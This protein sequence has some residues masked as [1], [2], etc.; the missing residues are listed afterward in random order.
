M[1]HSF[2]IITGVSGSGKTLALK[3][4]EDV[5]YFCID[6]MPTPLILNLLENKDTILPYHKKIAF[7]VDIRNGEDFYVLINAIAP[8]QK[9]KTARMVYLDCSDSVLVNRYKETRRKHPLMHRKDYS[10][11]KAVAYEKEILRPLF[12][13]ADFIIDSSLLSSFQLKDKLLTY[14]VNDEKKILTINI[15]S[16]GFKF[17]VPSDIDMLF[18]VRCL[19]NPFYIKELRDLTGNDEKVSSYVL[20][21]DEAQALYKNQKDLLNTVLPLYIKEGET[22]LTIAF[23]C[24]GGKHRSITFT[25][26][27]YNDLLEEGYQV[28][29]SHRDEFR[30]K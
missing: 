28:V 7:V 17:G 9:D 22:N 6:N 18:D 16:F 4:L 14:A 30:R 25:N 8:L 11:E 27:L 23:G 3:S 1:Q 5:G 19:L 24:T 21:F 15:M 13:S 29:K 10:L 12:A 26:K 20:S 2:V